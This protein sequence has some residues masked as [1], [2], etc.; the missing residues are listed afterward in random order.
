MAR[1]KT[2]AK[3]IGVNMTVAYGD[4]KYAITTFG[5]GS[6]V[7]IALTSVDP[8]KETLPAQSNPESA[9]HANF[10]KARPEPESEPDF[11]DKTRI[12][13]RRSDLET[14]ISNPVETLRDDYLGLK[15]V[16]EEKFFGRAYPK[17]T[18]RIQIANAI[19]D[20]QKILG[21]YVAD[22]LH[23]VDGLQDEP[24]DLVGLGLGAEKMKK[25]LA[26]S[27]PYLGFFGGSEVFILS[28]SRKKE[29]LTAADVHN[30]KVFRALGA[31]RQKLAHFKWE[32][33][34]VVFGANAAAPAKFFAGATGGAT[35]WNDVIA[36]LWRKRIE[37]VRRNFIQNAARNLWVLFRIYGDNPVLNSGMNEKQIEEEKKKAEP[38]QRER[39]RQYYHFSVLKDGKN[40]GFNLT[41]TREL[42]ID[43]NFPIFHDERPEIKRV[44]DTFRS[45]LY[46]I[47]DFVIFEASVR[48]EAS[49]TMGKVSL[50]KGAIN[51]ALD[52]L[53][54]A[55]DDDAKERIYEK[56]AASIKN[57]S[58]YTRLCNVCK[59][60]LSTSG[61][62]IFP[63]ELRNKDKLS[64]VNP[65]WLEA[66]KE[67][68]AS[69]FTQLIAF[70][71]NFLEGKEIN[72]LITALI[73]KFEGIQALIDLLRK[74]EGTDSVD[75]QP[76]FALFNENQSE[77]AGKIAGEL[78][79]LVSIGKMKPDMTDAKR[80]L[81]KNALTILGAKDEEM[82]DEWL[83]EHILLDKSREDLEEKKKDVN[84]FRNYIAKNVITSR[85]FYYLARYAKPS[86]VRKLMSN[87]KIV[88]YVLKRLPENQVDAYYRAI[89][90]LSDADDNTPPTLTRKI[91]RL[92]T[93]L[94]GFSFDV[95]FKK[96]NRD[97]IVSA[98]Q[99]REVNLEVERM[100]KLTTLYM[101]IAYI[102]VKNLVKVNA[103]YF[104]AYSALERD[105]ALFEAKYGDELRRHFISFELDGKPREFKY[106]AIL[107]YY[108][109][110]DAETLRRKREICAEISRLN[111]E[112]K[113][114]TTHTSAEEDAWRVEKK[115]LNAERKACEKKLHFSTRWALHAKNR[116]TNKA[117]NPQKW[118]DIFKNLRAELLEMQRTGWVATQARNDVEHLN[119][120]NQFAEYIE[121]VRRYPD[122][123]PRE[124]DYSITSYFEIFHYI[125]QR[126]YLENVVANKTNPKSRAIFSDEEMA[127]LE[128]RLAKIKK[129]NAPDIDLL[130]LE[131]LP[132]AYNLPRYKN[133]TIEALFDPDSKSGQDLEKEWRERQEKKREQRRQ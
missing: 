115:R 85:A 120:V 101:S 30:A 54:M 108:L 91:S 95:L 133:L 48:E 26:A 47:L 117:K 92:T 65:E 7:D 74:L 104:I 105:L 78:R 71:C 57:D 75:F 123:T 31:I 83:S 12:S 42:F 58:L 41:K 81:Y 39:V 55:P 67:E 25:L 60:F 40:L 77:T 50:W 62:P 130:K 70:L 19:L 1:K 59:L 99:T 80:I 103:R 29:D 24:T 11:V 76:E 33:S 27:R 66:T 125:R 86:A 43:Q 49:G 53:R 5:K 8:P 14:L 21:L 35:L 46:A 113:R 87:P 131:F 2:I 100:K 69:S 73:R 96:E 51:S 64:S 102:A 4:G 111:A 82:S 36:P 68:N 10:D 122:G 97:Q 52:Q 44:V 128:E 28:K 118:Y 45:K 88:R 126:V 37:R 119:T 107:D 127:K 56:L 114:K 106:L 38:K 72:E 23:F 6:K 132:F 61:V 89:W 18:I 63:A 93:E 116:D 9:I 121:D 79:L 3:Q 109:A 110:R 34:L 32:E 17:D 13:A 94:S 124:K 15:D 84:P 22:I 112:Y 129:R 90:T 20:I 16:I 98:S